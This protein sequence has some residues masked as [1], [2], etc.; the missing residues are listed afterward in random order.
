M[1]FILFNTHVLPH[2]GSLNEKGERDIIECLPVMAAAFKQTC[3]YWATF[4]APKQTHTHTHAQSLAYIQ[5]M[6]RGMRQD[7]FMETCG[8]GNV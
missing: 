5:T 3:W 8:S 6:L 4:P 2:A 7:P 1:N